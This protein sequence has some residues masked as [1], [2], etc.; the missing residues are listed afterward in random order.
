MTIRIPAACSFPG[1]EKPFLATPAAIEEYRGAIYRCLVQL[2]VLAREKKALQA[3]LDASLILGLGSRERTTHRL[4]LPSTRLT[5][6]A[7]RM[8][9]CYWF[10]MGRKPTMG[11]ADQL[12]G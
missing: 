12:S 9:R 2:Q 11:S 1:S 5:I 3:R 4:C 7:M 8:T 10:F 6:Q